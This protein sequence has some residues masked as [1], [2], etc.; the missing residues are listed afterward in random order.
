[1]SPRPASSPRR[2]HC[3]LQYMHTFPACPEVFNTHKG[4]HRLVLDGKRESG[5][6]VE[7]RDEAVPATTSAL[8]SLTP[9]C[10]VKL[11]KDS[12]ADYQVREIEHSAKCNKMAC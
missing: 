12:I 4:N 9:L 5:P 8:T 6:V 2:D 11:Q 1:M 3:P 7:Y 10:R